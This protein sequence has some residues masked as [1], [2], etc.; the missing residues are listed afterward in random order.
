MKETRA[1]RGSLVVRGRVASAANG[2]GDGGEEGAWRGGGTL[3][4]EKSGR[5]GGEGD[6]HRNGISL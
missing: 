1:Y 4:G 6:A 2:V 3:G 5:E